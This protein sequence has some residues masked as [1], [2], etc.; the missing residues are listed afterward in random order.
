MSTMSE[1]PTD[2]SELRAQLVKLNVDVGPINERTRGLYQDML[3]KR[4][5]NQSS[6]PRPSQTAGKRALAKR[7]EKAKRK[8]QTAAKAQAFCEDTHQE[9]DKEVDDEVPDEGI[10]STLWSGP[11]K[12][13]E[14]GKKAL[15]GDEPPLDDTEPMEVGPNES[16]EEENESES[17]EVEEER[18]YPE[19][20]RRVVASP[21]RPLRPAS[22]AQVTAVRKQDKDVGRK[23]Y[24]IARQPIGAFRREAGMPITQSDRVLK[25]DWELEPWSV[26]ICRR[27]N[28]SEWKL[29][30]GG[31][32]EV[33]KALK[34]GVD[35]V[36]VKRIKVGKSAQILDQFR[37]EVELISHLRH[38]HIVQ[39]YG[40]CT[41]PGCFYMVTELMDCDLYSALHGEDFIS[42]MWTGR[43]GRNVIRAIAS[44]LNYLHSRSP[45]VVHR[46]LKSPNVLL[47]DGVAKIADI[48][49][50]RTKLET[51]M[52][53][54]P[55]F[56]PIWSAPEV[57]YRE[58]ANEKVDI[59]SLGVILWEVVTG[60]TPHMGD[61]RLPVSCE[62]RLR[63]LFALC[64]RRQPRERPDAE[65]VVRT[66][67]SF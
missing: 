56:T 49:L 35:E 39:F 29:G 43:H 48:G 4:L 46:D 59:F 6:F 66:L 42:Y 53:P 36:A 10:L 65:D 25:S 64:V 32:A 3:R 15:F 52:T 47:A 37:R 31:F 19:Q 51:L 18:K 55:G 33:Y 50:A 11:R 61:L 41:Q 12:L 24:G 63:R 2:D 5:S 34:D 14:A 1:V 40:A 16:L 38:R 17:G 62:T 20:V 54:Q 58:R 8:P 30:Q 44:G 28:G 22:P 67:N 13:W 27:P 57:I 21:R 45:P 9:T 26:S 7:K 23:K 60:E